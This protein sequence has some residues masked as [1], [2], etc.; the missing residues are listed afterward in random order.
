MNAVS[1]FTR[2]KPSEPYINIDWN[3]LVIQRCAVTLK[4][5]I[6][7]PK[8]KI[9]KM[10]ISIH[11]HTIKTTQNVLYVKPLYFNIILTN[12]SILKIFSISILYSICIYLSINAYRNAYRNYR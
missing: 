3:N 8:N 9:N 1:P 5:A 7:A 11:K 2:I 4:A 12:I 10:I 6:F